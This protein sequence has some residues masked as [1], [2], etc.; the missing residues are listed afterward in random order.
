[1]AETEMKTTRPLA[2]A[3]ESEPG[4]EM[5]ITV[6]TVAILALIGILLIFTGYQAAESERMF[7][8]EVAMNANQEIATLVGRQFAQ[9]FTNST[10]LLE[11]LARFPAAINRDMPLLDELFSVLLKR[12]DLFR[13]VYMLDENGKPLKVR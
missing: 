5:R 7:F 4:V 3:D 12:H 8:R 6:L 11:D 10:G 1:M 13:V 9:T 2:I